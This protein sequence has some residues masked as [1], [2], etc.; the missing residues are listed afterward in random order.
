MT[1]S[2][3]FLQMSLKY[4]NGLYCS[5]RLG[6]PPFPFFYLTLKFE[7]PWVFFLLH[8]DYLYQTSN[9][10]T[11]IFKLK[12]T[13]SSSYLSQWGFICFLTIQTAYVDESQEWIQ[14]TGIQLHASS[15][16]KMLFPSQ[17]WKKKYFAIYVP[18]THML[19]NLAIYIT[20]Q[21][22]LI[23]IHYKVHYLQREL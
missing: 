21:K 11:L 2:S 20:K 22:M 3:Y 4:E 5:S 7:L 14:S 13:R 19:K 6:C 18:K 16:F 1:F 17:E 23:K 10:L 9:A 12:S 8:T 15:T